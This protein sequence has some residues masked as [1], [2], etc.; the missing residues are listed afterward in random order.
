MPPSFFLLDIHSL[1]TDR[2]VPQTPSSAG[3]TL[4]S[5]LQDRIVEVWSLSERGSPTQ[6]RSRPGY[7]S[8]ILLFAATYSIALADA[9][10]FLESYNGI[11]TLYE[12]R[13]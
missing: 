9:E 2:L 1:S 8:P 7:E 5:G 3:P 10:V 11:P 6:C 12:N 13:S 4:T